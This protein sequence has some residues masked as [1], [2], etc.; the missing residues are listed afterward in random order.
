MSFLIKLYRI[1]GEVNVKEKKMLTNVHVNNLALIEETEIEFA[2]GLN[3]LTG[4]TG[5]G[6]SIIIGSINYCLGQKADKDVIREGAEYALVELSFV[7]ESDD[8]KKQIEAM[9]VTLEEDGTL[10][11]SRKIMPSRSV[12]KV[13]GEAVTAKQ[14]K[15]LAAFLI[16]IHGQHEHQSL[17]SEKKQAKI[18]DAYTGEELDN[19]KSELADLYSEYL[20]TK[21]KLDSLSMDEQQRARE[22]SLAE[23]EVNEIENAAL[24]DD[25]EEEKLNSQYKLMLNGKKIAEA[26]SKAVNYVS[27]IDGSSLEL[28]GRALTEL[29]DV[30]GVSDKAD[31][32]TDRLAEV[33]DILN[34]LSKDAKRYIDELDYS[35]EEFANTEQRLNV[36]NHLT[37]K[38]GG[39]IIKVKDYLEKRKQ[40][41]DELNRID[42]VRSE[43]KDKI[44]KLEKSILTKCEKAHELRVKEAKELTKEI[45]AVLEELN[46]LK[47]NFDIEVSRKESFNAE[48]YDDIT[49][50]ISL[51]PGEKIRPLSMVASGGELSRIMLAL[52]TVFADNDNIGTLIF[53]E[54]DT[55]ISGKTAWKVSERMGVIARSHQVICITHLP[56]IAAMADRHFLIEKSE[57][58][59]K[60]VTNL[61]MVNEESRIDELSRMLGSDNITDTVRANAI[62]L[63]ENANK[64]KG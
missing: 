44:D 48:G 45:I 16:D 39:S 19:I 29:S 62:E 36:I 56:Q 11:L 49:F 40:E 57:K 22:I 34:D 15:E 30:S 21:E 54:I 7:I 1:L 46:F 33:E 60:T 8:I 13:N 20:D 10:I 18:L 63:I 58:D 4:E 38:Y 28:I 14:M 53:D 42:S 27:G 31:G 12:F 64:V 51:N 59:G 2:E 24:E 43:M 52:K 35:E 17:L 23:F 55:G 47:V 6:K 50:M 9:D 41:L 37:M 32:F 61:N 26:V 5:A 3:I 25:D